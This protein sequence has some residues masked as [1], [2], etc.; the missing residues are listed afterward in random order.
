LVSSV[1]AFS[2]FMALF[3]PV[4]SIRSKTNNFSRPEGRTLDGE[5]LFPST[6]AE[7]A[8]W[9]RGA[10]RG[11]IAEAV[12]GSYSTPHAR[13]ATYSGNQNVLGWDFHEIQ[14]R[15]D[16]SLVWPRK[17]KVATLYCTHSWGIAQP[18]LEEFQIRYVVIGDVEHST[19]LEGSDYC[20]NGLQDEKFSQNLVMVFQNESLIIFEVPGYSK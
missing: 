10:P 15:G 18:I 16:G 7:G 20:P 13:M 9:L 17:E 2:M 5:Y 11:V 14:W 4:I 1:L 6:D 3:Y 12:G 19:Y 8:A